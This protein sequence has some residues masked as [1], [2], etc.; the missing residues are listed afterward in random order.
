MAHTIELAVRGGRLKGHYGHHESP[1]GAGRRVLAEAGLI[2]SERPV[3]ETQRPVDAPCRTDQNHQKPSV[4]G[5]GNLAELSLS[6]R[7][8][9]TSV[10][11][12]WAADTIVP[13]TRVEYK[14][15]RWLSI[16]G[17]RERELAR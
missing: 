8:S 15:I 2:S 14:R 3:S 11:R 7:T 13:V 4:L 12:A 1:N 16:L 10:T 6:V 5:C 9:S 17:G